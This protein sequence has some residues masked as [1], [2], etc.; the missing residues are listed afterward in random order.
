MGNNLQI[1]SFD[2]QSMRIF[3]MFS[4][5]GDVRLI[6]HEFDTIEN[7]EKFIDDNIDVGS[8]LFVQVFSGIL[9]LELV[10]SVLSLLSST[11]RDAKIIGATTTG[12]INNGHM[13][14]QKIVISFSIFEATQVKTYYF[15]KS[16][17]QNGVDAGSQID[18]KKT[19]LCIF[20]SEGLKNDAQ[21][22]LD[23]FTSTC[24]DIVI[25]GGNAGDN[26]L[27]N[28]TYVFKDENIY[29]EG[30]VLAL[31][32]SDVLQ[33]HNAYSL[34]WTPIGKEMIVTKA[35]KNV[36]Y[37]IDNVPV[38]ELY[39]HY[40]GKETIK[41]IPASAIEFPLVKQEEGVSI[42]RSIIA[43]TPDGGFVYAGHFKNGEKVRFAIGNV[44]EVLNNAS[45]IQSKIDSK[46]TQ[47]V[48]IYSCSV[49]KLFLKNQLEYELG[50]INDVAP[51]SGMFTYGEFFH[52]N[53][54][55]SL[56]NITTT[57]V[58]LSESLEINLKSEHKSDRVYQH[59]MLKSLSH[60]VNSTQ[61]ELDENIKFLD[62]YKM[63][64]DES[65]IV[66][67]TDKKGVI[68]YVNDAFCEVS[69]YTR[70]ELIGQKHNITRH[71]EVPASLFLELWQT[72]FSGQ[73]W[74]GLF[75]NLS[76]DGK[77]YYLKSVIA[78]IFDESGNI[79]EFIA[80]RVDVTELIEKEQTIQRH[81]YDLL[82]GLR[83]RVAMSEDLEQIKKTVILV[84]VNIDSFSTI[85]DYFGYEL[86]DELLRQFGNTLVDL[87]GHNEVYHVSADEFVIVCKK[88]R[89]DEEFKKYFIDLLNHIEEKR[90]YAGD[91]EHRLSVTTGIAM[92]E[93]ASV[94]EL[95]HLAYKEAK[96]LRKKY[97]FFN[98]DSFL[99]QKTHDNFL[100]IKKI[101]EAIEN[102][103][104][105]PYYQGIV[106][107]QTG[108]IQKYEAL[109]RIIDE[110]GRVLSPYQFL[111]HAKKAKLYEY[112][113]RIMVLKT[114][115][116]AQECE[117]VFSINLTYNDIVSDELRDFIFST[118]SSSHASERIIFEI[119]ESEGIENF[120]KV[121]EFIHDVKKF[122]CRI[123]ID[124]FGSGYS[125]FSYLSKMQA[126]YIKV[127]G[128]LI[129]HIIDDE[130]H[131][132]TVKSILF[133]AKAK[134]IKI[135]AE[136]VENE[137][138]Q[139]KVVELGIDYS[140]GYLF[141]K[142]DKNLIQ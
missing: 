16:D 122:G 102:D 113:T 59:T 48:Y 36:I 53:T 108:Q 54:K 131:L 13:S 45:K 72:L 134:G 75:Q 46:P 49:R 3:E 23:G 74:K 35:E 119:V 71:P 88:D 125:N 115:K 129:R 41:E 69:G 24:K 62:Q 91:Y 12:E 79:T 11:L 97:V 111:E 123:A 80:S 14:D 73:I 66:S 2:V 121:G 21:S 52:A 101:R 98:D 96:E 112:L 110:D 142:P 83:S 124:D 51:C 126:D 103:R 127:D 67:K 18:S 105:V 7:L 37:E 30:V 141:S 8:C 138:I 106:D 56:L 26:Y 39:S 68:T 118:L 130:D 87:A 70:E 4:R 57:A 94:Y 64:L 1:E 107:N 137:E 17:Y 85:N 136:F 22:F 135:I 89:Y 78:P 65:S 19:K 63:V 81:R 58:A 40:L 31:F 132:L 93:N 28:Q 139:K 33:V 82:T 140:Q 29:D 76:K 117:A 50:L 133:F 104:V 120:A 32:E 77:T 25:A 90:Y 43:Q 27:F 128:S 109:M 10:Q 55:N 92:E 61:G 114:I 116:K 47:G 86:G 84:V 20:L 5:E 44:E 100:T 42:A 95:A 99:I 15:P 9:D 6:N 60:L 38:R 34:E